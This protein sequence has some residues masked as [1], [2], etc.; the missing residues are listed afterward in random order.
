VITWLVWQVNPDRDEIKEFVA[1][2]LKTISSN[3]DSEVRAA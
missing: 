1:E 2:R 3:V